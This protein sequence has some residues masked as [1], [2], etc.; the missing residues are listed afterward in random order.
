MVDE[1]TMLQGVSKNMPFNV[2]AYPNS[3]YVP[4]P[5]KKD[6]IRVVEPSTRADVNMTA[7]RDWQIQKQYWRDLIQDL[8]LREYL[9]QEVFLNHP[10]NKN[11]DISV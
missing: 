6:K 3:E 5:V 7:L 1:T 9:N 4:P 8:R 11:I 2:M 10:R